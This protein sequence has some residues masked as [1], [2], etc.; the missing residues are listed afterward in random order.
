MSVFI[1]FINC[2]LI[3]FAKLEENSIELHDFDPVS[4]RDSN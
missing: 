1:S 2:R 3:L 4:S